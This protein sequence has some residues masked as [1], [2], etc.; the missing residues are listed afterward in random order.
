MNKIVWLIP[1]ICLSC[2]GLRMKPEERFL[3]TSGHDSAIFII[4]YLGDLSEKNA[5]AMLI[6]PSVSASAQASA[7]VD[8]FSEKNKTSHFFFDDSLAPVS[9]KMF[10]SVIKKSPGATSGF[11][12]YLY[13][14]KI[15][16]SGY[17][18]QPLEI[19]Y[20]FEKQS[21]F[22]I[23]TSENGIQG[24]KPLKTRE[25]GNLFIHVLDEVDSLFV[26]KPGIR[27]FWADFVIN[28][29]PQTL[30]FSKEQNGTITLLFAS[31]KLTILES[32]QSLFRVQTENGQLVDFRQENPGNILPVKSGY[33]AIN[34][35]IF[36]N[37]K[38]VGNALIYLLAQP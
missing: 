16:F 11:D 24:I 26:R 35:L 22:Q 9:G 5:R 21:P 29:Q 18:N 32:E 20:A 25:N 8:I 17:G 30:Y 34:A 14:N 23:E 1:L 3:A 6:S 13:R 36:E 28:N 31:E 15:L 10:P 37:E 27:Y 38:P 19:A 7:L 4:T 33:N 2:S 12:F